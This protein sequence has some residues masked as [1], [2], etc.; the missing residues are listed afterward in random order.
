[1]LAKIG[2]LD[3]RILHLGMQSGGNFDEQNLESSD[4]KDLGVGRILD[5]LASLRERNLIDMTQKGKFSVTD[6]A[7]ELLWSKDVPLWL[8]ILRL[9]EIKSFNQSEISKY[10]LEQ[11]D[12][13]QNSLEKLRKNQL[14]VMEPI[15]K[16]EKLEKIFEILQD[17]KNELEKIEEDGYHNADLVIKDKRNDV[18]ILQTIDQMIRD[19]Q[20][21]DAL[22]DE[23]KKDFV[24]RLSL[25]KDKLGI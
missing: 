4:L 14:V 5:T 10:L 25:L 3:L 1:M 23:K 17:G 20:G 7:K 21:E 12:M 16:E 2:V 24:N 9:L 8:R 18:E 6:T 11:E 15:R 22:P 19:L 13:I